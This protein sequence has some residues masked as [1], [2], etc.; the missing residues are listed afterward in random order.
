MHIISRKITKIR[1]PRKP[2]VL[3]CLKTTDFAFL[4]INL[5]LVLPVRVA[6]LPIILEEKSADLVC[7]ISAFSLTLR[8]IL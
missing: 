8:Q 5:R 1:P 4:F 3:N 7:L 2:R 6:A